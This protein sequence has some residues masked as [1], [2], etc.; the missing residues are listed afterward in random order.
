MVI[1][2][3]VKAF[4]WSPTPNLLIERI[5]PSGSN[6][7][8]QLSFKDKLLYPINELQ[9]KEMQTLDESFTVVTTN[10]ED[11][12]IRG[13]Y[14]FA[15]SKDT[16]VCNKRFSDCNIHCDGYKQEELLFQ[17]NGSEN[18]DLYLSYKNNSFVKAEFN[19]YLPCNYYH[20]VDVSHNRI[21][22]AASHGETQ[23]NLYVSEIIDEKRA[24]F[25]LSL[26]GILTFFPNS[27]WKDSWL[28]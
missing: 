22:V 9:T 5:E 8:W 4:F 13:D 14:K 24:T 23:V 27:T 3:Y 20:I 15:T 6:T 17:Q 18:L 16:K 21:F 26:E 19:T 10:V 1:H 11:F 28:K 7:V 12:Q 2:H 25:T